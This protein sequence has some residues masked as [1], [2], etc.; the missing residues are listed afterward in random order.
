MAKFYAVKVGRNPGVYTSWASCKEQVDKFPG[1]VYKSFATKQEAQEYIQ[2]VKH[3]FVEN[4]LLAYVDGSFNVKTKEYGYGCVFLEGQTV[5]KEVYGKGNSP[6]YVTMR[7]VSGEIIGSEVAVKYAIDHG[8]PAIYIYYDYEGIEKWAKGLWKA[9]KPGT[10]AYASLMQEYQK[11]IQ[12][13][14]V[15]VAAH[16][17]DLYNERADALAKKAVGISG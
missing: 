17:G 13:V 11:Q 7:N 4:G 14:F 6:E 3:T 9:N 12:I 8:Y 1:A 2:E 5:I 16:T 15:K 10:I